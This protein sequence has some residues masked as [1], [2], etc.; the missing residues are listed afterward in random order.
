MASFYPSQG[1]GAVLWP[2]GHIPSSEPSPR[3][4]QQIAGWIA[5][6]LLSVYMT[7]MR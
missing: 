5:Y 3:T 1:Y 6:M 2:S 4:A 7:K